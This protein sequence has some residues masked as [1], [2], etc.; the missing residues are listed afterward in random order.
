MCVDNTSV[1]MIFRKELY[2]GS[3]HVR[4]RITESGQIGN[5]IRLDLQHQCHYHSQALQ[6][7]NGAE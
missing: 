3:V 6:N 2:S 5:D 4:D 1:T 7:M